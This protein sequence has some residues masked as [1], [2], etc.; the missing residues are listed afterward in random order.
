MLTVTSLIR[1]PVKSIGGE[2]LPEAWVDARGISGDRQWGVRDLA[3][4]TVL[5]GRRTPQLLLANARIEGVAATSAFDASAS[6]VIITLPDGTETNDDAVLSA[7]LGTDVALQRAAG[8]AGGTFENPLT[9]AGLSE[10]ASADGD[11]ISWTGPAGSLHDSGRTMISLASAATI[12]AWDTRRFRKNVLTDGSGEDDLVGKAIHIGNVAA[13]V[14][15]RIDR[16]VMVTRP[17]PGAER[18]LDV[19]KTINRDREMC[20]GIGMLITHPST[21]SV[22]DTVTVDPTSG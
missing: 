5:T 1:Y 21:V 16:C 12:G 13:D 7:W 10:D 9:V 11:W 6:T 4:D 20:L 15:K 14:T 18:D 17:L 2:E 3:S 22:G 8:D 19:L